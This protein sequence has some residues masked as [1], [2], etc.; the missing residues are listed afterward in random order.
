MQSHDHDVALND[1]VAEV[2]L[3][4]SFTAL[5]F[6]EIKAGFRQDQPRGCDGRRCGGSG[7]VVV[8][9]RQGRQAGFECSIIPISDLTEIY[10]EID[11][12]GPRAFAC[13]FYF[14]TFAGCAGTWMAVAACVERLGGIAFD[15]QEGKLFAADDAIRYSHDT[16]ASVARLEA[17]FSG[18]SAG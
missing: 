11:F 12:G 18:P 17:T 14:A 13:A 7:S 2:R 1:A 6:L 3:N 4:L 10:P 16:L 9:Q 5:R 15:P 8:T